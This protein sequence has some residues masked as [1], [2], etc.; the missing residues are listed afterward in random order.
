VQHYRDLTNEDVADD[1]PADARDHPDR[2]GSDD[3]EPV[4]QSELG[5][6]H[7][8]QTETSCVK[9]QIGAAKTLHLRVHAK[10][11]ETGPGGYRQIWPMA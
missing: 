10:G 3:S 1:S 11:D 2:A 6:R 4:L 9:D 7:G 8:E 5:R